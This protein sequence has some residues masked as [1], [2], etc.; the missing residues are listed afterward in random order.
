MIKNFLEDLS[1]NKVGYKLSCIW[2]VNAY[3][4]KCFFIVVSVIHRHGIRFLHKLHLEASRAVETMCTLW[5]D[6]GHGLD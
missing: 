5:L 4:P 1:M 6:M 2:F 3:I